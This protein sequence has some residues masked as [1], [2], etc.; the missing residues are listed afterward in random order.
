MVTE[1]TSGDC[2]KWTLTSGDVVVEI[3]ATLD[4]SGNVNFNYD[5]VSGTADLNG[6]YIDLAN[7]GGDIKRLEGG[8][9]MN[10]SDTDGDKLDG[11][12]WATIIGTTGGN[13]ADT[14]S[15]S[16]TVSMAELNITSLA[17]LA[18]S[19]LGIRATSVGDDR[20]GSLKLAD[21]GELCED[22]PDPETEIILDF[23]ACD[24]G[25]TSITLVFL[26]PDGAVRGDFNLDSYRT[27]SVDFTTAVPADADAFINDLVA[28]LIA[29]DQFLTEDVS[30]LKGAFLYCEGESGT[31]FFHYGGFNANGETS[32]YPI[33]LVVNPDG[34]IGPD[35][36]IDGSYSAALGADGFAFTEL[37]ADLMV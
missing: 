16:I 1:P 37:T 21:T 10:G 17:D 4:G 7:D 25:L 34:T 12:D 32:D 9:N 13:D 31:E 18:D 26:Q 14:T 15:G 2:V 6:F 22:E 33:G 27:V 28:D 3:T 29:Q 8:N 19:E 30:I 20:E 11:F 35:G 23:P 24:A 5:L 36:A